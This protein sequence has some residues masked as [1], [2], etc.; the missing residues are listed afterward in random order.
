MPFKGPEKAFQRPLKS[1]L[2]G[3]SKA[4][5]RPSKACAPTTPPYLLPPTWAERGSLGGGPPRAQRE[6]DQGRLNGMSYLEKSD[7]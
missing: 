1:P 5:E 7:P 2:K 4:F 6:Y 3:V